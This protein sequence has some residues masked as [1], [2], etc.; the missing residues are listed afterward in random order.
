MMLRI[1]IGSVCKVEVLAPLNYKH[2]SPRRQI[3]KRPESEGKF[4]VSKQSRASSRTEAFLWS[5]VEELLTASSTSEQA[6]QASWK[7]PGTEL[8]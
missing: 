5:L 6:S 8:P 7:P 2:S 4:V 1:V 3:F